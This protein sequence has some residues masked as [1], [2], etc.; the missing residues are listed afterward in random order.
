MAF[1]QETLYCIAPN[2][3]LLGDGLCHNFDKYNTV[4]CNFDAGDCEDFNNKYPSTCKAEYPVFLGDGICNGGN[5]NTAECAFDGGDCDEFN[6]KFPGCKIDNPKLIGNGKCDHDGAYNTAECAFDGGDCL[7]FWDKYPEC[8][9]PVKSMIADG[10]CDGSEYNT[11]ECAWDGGDCEI[12]NSKY[13]DC[14]VQL[15]YRIGNNRCHG[16]EYNTA[17]CHFDGGDCLEFNE[18]YPNCDVQ[19]PLFLKNGRCDSGT[20]NTIECGWDDGDCLQFNENYP[21]CKVLYPSKIGNGICNGGDYY[22]FE[23]GFDGGDCDEFWEEHPNCTLNDPSMIGNG[24]CDESANTLDC[25]FDLGECLTAAEKFPGCAFDEEKGIFDHHLGY[26]NLNFNSKECGYDN[27]NCLAFNEKYPDCD[28][29]YPFL[30]GNGSCDDIYNNPEC[31][32]DGGD[33]KEFNEKYPFC[34]I[35]RSAGIG[36]GI[37]DGGEYNT[38]ECGFDEGDCTEFNLIYPDCH[39]V[40]IEELGDGLCQHNTQGCNYDDGDCILFNALYPDCPVKDPSLIGNGYCNEEYNTVQCKSDGGDCVTQS[41]GVLFINGEQM[42]VE[43]Y[44]KKTMVYALIQTASSLVSLAASIGII[45]VI[46]MSLKKLSLP[47]HRLL[48]GLSLADIIASLAQMFSTMPSPNSFDVIWNARGNKELCR[49]QGFL[50]FFGCT[51]APLYNC[52]LCI[53]YLIVVTYRK[54]RNA[55]SYVKGNIEILLHTVPILISLAGATAILSMNAFNPNMTYCY[56]GADPTC[57]DECEKSN[58]KINTIFIVFSAVPYII[59]PFVIAS[60]MLIMFRKAKM[61]ER[62][63]KKFG[64]GSL[65][66]KKN[67]HVE[68]KVS[69]DLVW[70]ERLR[71]SRFLFSI[72]SQISLKSIPFISSLTSHSN[73]DLALPTTKGPEKPTQSEPSSSSHFIA[74]RTG[75]SL[76]GRSRSNVSRKQTR[77]IVNRAFAYSLSFFCTYLFPIIISI[78]TLIGLESGPVLSILARIF[79]PLQGFFNF[80]VFMFP[81]VVHEKN[82][83]RTGGI[84]W[85]L[86]FLY[87]IRARDRPA[88]IKSNYR[89]TKK[90]AS[91]SRDADI[92]NSKGNGKEAVRV[93]FSTSAL[94]HS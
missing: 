91:A 84:S 83:S 61:D 82:A 16:Q 63:M 30:L 6:V 15:P 74:K 59:L 60:T 78:R 29:T 45:C 43:D 38:F 20:Y 37:C 54:G 11:E 21:D 26:C 62:K 53:Y 19:Y 47:F 85:Y 76:G 28:A 3:S 44:K 92:Y 31:L 67:S 35:K 24:A 49:M 8:V 13:P 71:R 14:D 65:S 69:E 12:Y 40:L 18:K 86:A 22:T 75:R 27:G 64:I 87:A 46:F 5:Y 36:D 70:G 56:I 90:K 7:D 81:K 42:S 72:P 32:Y 2:P 23:C 25:A 10:F 89:K 51:A 41:K 55:D 80:V 17:A 73:Q 66:L 1:Y 58:K 77:A 68:K 88:A 93:K 34:N 94:I 50:I 4:G 39:G 79:F 33:C 9:V 52:S 48:V 57:D